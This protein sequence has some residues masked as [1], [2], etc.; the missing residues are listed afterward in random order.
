M[1]TYQ[2]DLIWHNGSLI[3]RDE[4]TDHHINHSQHYGGGVFE[5]IRFY[6]TPQWPKIF[7]LKEHIQRFFYSAKVVGIVLPYTEEELINACIKTVAENKIS[8]WYIRPIA[9]FGKWKMGIYPHIDQLQTQVFISVWKRGKYLSEEPITVKIAK[10]RRIHP[11]TS[12]MKAKISGH[13]AN[14][15]QVS[16]ETRNDWYDEWLLLDTDWY[17]AEWPWENIFFINDNTICTPAEGTIL[18]GITR[19]TVIQLFKDTYWL[20]VEERMIHP[21]ELP[22]FTEAFFVWTAAEV[23]PIWSITTQD[24]IVYTYQWSW[25]KQKYSQQMKKLYQNIVTG[26]VESYHSWLW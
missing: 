14:S 25:D 2:T 13:Y 1:L 4:A 8:Q 21:D 23:T 22:D 11:A 16:L 9:Y 7:R 19:A 5:G 24:G 18:P 6:D 10:I 26:N 20:S 17:I 15:I 12:D 3:E